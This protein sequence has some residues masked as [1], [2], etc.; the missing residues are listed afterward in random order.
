MDT[1]LVNSAADWGSMGELGFVNPIAAR[2]DDACQPTAMESELYSQRK[3]VIVADEE[4]AEQPAKISCWRRFK[5]GIRCMRNT[6]ISKSCFM[7]I[8][9]LSLCVSLSFYLWL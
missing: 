4:A 7:W 6:Y 3:K 8:S 1:G 2:Y 9:V 5:A